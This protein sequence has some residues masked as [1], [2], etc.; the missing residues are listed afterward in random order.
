MT[1]L[2]GGSAMASA[3]DAHQ[4]FNRVKTHLNKCIY[5]R[6]CI[7]FDNLIFVSIK[8]KQSNSDA[9]SHLSDDKP[10][11]VYKRTQ[12]L[13]PSLASIKAARV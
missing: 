7:G 11:F 12:F 1:L 10:A 4:S 2:R 3:I 6:K 9:Y 13:V 5:L 8:A